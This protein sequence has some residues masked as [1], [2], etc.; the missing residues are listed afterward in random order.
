M[1]VIP[2]RAAAPPARAFKGVARSA[3]LLPPFLYLCTTAPRV[4][5]HVRARPRHVPRGDGLLI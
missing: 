4:P 2:R 1:G 3:V 5:R